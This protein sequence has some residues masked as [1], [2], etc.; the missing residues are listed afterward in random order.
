[1]LCPHC[2]NVI[3]KF[4][5]EDNEIYCPKCFVVIKDKAIL[6]VIK[7][8]RLTREAR[9]QETELILSGEKEYTK[10]QLQKIEFDKKRKNK[11]VKYFKRY[12]IE[13]RYPK[14][15]ETETLNL[16]RC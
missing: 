9:G 8:L 16:F 4:I 15:D 13:K 5:S 2:H 1:M 14:L 6:Y 10:R 3:D 7:H 11:R 12:Y